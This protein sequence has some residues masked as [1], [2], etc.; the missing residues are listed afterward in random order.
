MSLN[1]SKEEDAD[2]E[3]IVDFVKSLSENA[4]YEVLSEEIIFRIPIKDDKNEEK[5]LK[6]ILDI[7]NFFKM[8]DEN[9]NNLKIKSYSISMPTLEDVFLNVAAEDDKR[10]QKEKEKEYQLV[11]PQESNEQ[12]LFES[13]LKHKYTGCE[14]LTEIFQFQ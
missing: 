1:V 9:I 5:K 14:N 13:D 3:T 7:P 2:N 11:I 10:I 8:F 12:L 4:E 6:K